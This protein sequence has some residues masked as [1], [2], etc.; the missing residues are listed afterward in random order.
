[1]RLEPNEHL[2]VYLP[3]NRDHDTPSAESKIWIAPSFEEAIKSI[4]EFMFDGEFVADVECSI[5]IFDSTLTPVSDQK[6]IE[7]LLLGVYEE[8]A[9]L[10]EPWDDD[11]SSSPRRSAPAETVNL[12]PPSTETPKKSEKEVKFSDIKIEDGR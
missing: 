1:M 7:D 12:T 11:P 5:E 2:I 6:M 3:I 9:E 4:E 8:Q 10:P